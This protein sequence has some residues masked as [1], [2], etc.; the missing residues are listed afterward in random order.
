MITLDQLKKIFATTPRDKLAAYVDPINALVAKY[1]IT[2]KA[3]MAMFLAQIGHESAGLSTV[4][5][6][7]NYSQ[8]GLLNTFGRYYNSSTAAAHARNPEKIA[9]RVY[10]SRMG[11]GNEESGDG[12]RFR[13][14][15]AIQI[16]G[17]SNY[18]ELKTDLALP[19]LT[20]TTEYLTTPKGVIESAMWF[21]SKRGLNALAD[22][23]KI[24]EATKKINGGTNGLAERKHLYQLALSVL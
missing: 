13:G 4:T 8:A 24:T 23:G 7:L 15:G 22:A 16:T 18:S 12:Y 1:G 10:A 11:N 19:S 21:W 2:T 17:R 3:R 20:A 9:N 6:N 5:E 14:R